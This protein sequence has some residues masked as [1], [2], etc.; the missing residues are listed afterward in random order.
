MEC[1]GF[2][3]RPLVQT[4]ALQTCRKK[5]KQSLDFFVHSCESM[6]ALS[7]E[8]SLFNAKFC[9]RTGHATLFETD[10]TGSRVSSYL[11]HDSVKCAEYELPTYVGVLM[12]PCLDQKVLS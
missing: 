10:M 5:S 11:L 9:A 2:E 3:S 4:Y 1:N 6:M 7:F 12:I 8:T